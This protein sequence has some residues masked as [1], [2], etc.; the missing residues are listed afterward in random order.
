MNTS[1]Q[2]LRSTATLTA[3]VLT[4]LCGNALA[5]GSAAT[6]ITITADGF[7]P[8]TAEPCPVCLAPPVKIT[9]TRTGSFTNPLSVG[10]HS[11]GTATPGVDYPAAID[12]LVIPA[13]KSSASFLLHALDDALPE[14]PEIAEISLKPGSTTAYSIGSPGRVQVVIADDEAGAPAERLDYK[15]P[16]NGAAFPS[17][18][19]SIR[20]TAIAVSST[21]EIDA[22][23]QFLANGV[24]LGQS[25]PIGFGRPPIPWLPREHEFVWNAPPDGDYVLTARTPANPGPW[26]EAAPIHITVGAAHVRPV[27]S[28]IATSRIAEEDSAP[29]MRAM[30]LRGVFTIS[31]TGS[32]AQSQN[33]Y[34]LVSGTAV[35]GVD[36]TALPFAVSIPAGSASAVVH[37]DAIRDN[38]SEPLETVIAEVSNCPPEPLMPPCFDFAI[39]PAHQRD[40]VF[41]RDDGITRATLEITEPEKGDHFTSGGDIVINA[42]AIDIDGAITAVDF[43]A[44]PQKIGDSQIYFIVQPPPGSPIYHTF[45]WTGAPA[46]THTLTVRAVASSGTEIVSAPVSVT[47]GGNQTPHVVLT[48]PAAGAQFPV[49]SPVEITAAATDPDGYTSIAEFFA[50]GH[51]LGEVTLNFLVPP[52]P[53]ETQT[54]TFTWRDAPP[55]THMLSASVRDDGGATGVSAPVT[56]IVAA[57]DSL[58]T[59]TVHSLDPYSVE[60]AAGF[61]LNTG[62]FRLRRLGSTAGDLAVNYSLTGTATNGADYSTL[63]GTAIFSSGQAIT[64]VTVTPLADTLTEHRETVILQIE[65]QFDDGPERYHVGAHRRAIL[66]IADRGWMSPHPAGNVCSP[67]GDGLFHL[68]FP[69]PATAAPG[70][71]VEATDNF[72]V[73]ETVHEA[74]SID[75]AIHFVDPETPGVNR[76][77][78]RMAEDSAAAGP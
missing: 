14:G 34:L 61:P 62:S 9:V 69:A 32:T 48:T 76:R 54:F 68:C 66:V 67:L 8:R 37:V 27:I 31:R 75:D 38:F 20:L 58:P 53:G 24:V 1:G 15:A 18:T 43:Y 49:G 40:T 59:I 55:G 36:Y 19:T 45:T 3:L 46:G 77:F 44:G 50:N 63:N 6:V 21:R 60:P 47:V 2:W 13:G 41:V 52:P 42:T 65:P 7:P 70:F 23:V 25:N 30:V 51:K 74:A 29:T 71:R 35:P 11:A 17:G 56:I 10:L 12:P 16:E 64:V 5:Q 26:L 78:Y 73:W 39:D 4:L 57:A 22:P 28:I 72:H 33:V